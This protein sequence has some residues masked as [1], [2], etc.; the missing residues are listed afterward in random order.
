MLF[1]SFTYVQ[2]Q[3][4]VEIRNDEAYKE[5]LEEHIAFATSEEYIEFADFIGKFAKLVPEDFYISFVGGTSNF[6]EWISSRINDSG[7]ESIEDAVTQY[8]IYDEKT[9][10]I[11]TKQTELA[12]EMGKVRKKF[13]DKELFRKVFMEDFIN[14]N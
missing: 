12:V 13:Q 1:L 7:F 14:A 4:E 10:I 11:Y 8:K 3:T 5:M 9:N 2:A 6:E